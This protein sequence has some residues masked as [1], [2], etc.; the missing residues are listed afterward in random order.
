MNSREKKIVDTV[1]E[2][3][4]EKGPK[5]KMEDV[6]FAMKMS[7]KTIYKDFGNK[8]DLIILIVK[9]IFEGIEKQ[10]EKIIK[11]DKYDTLEK[12]IRI[13]CAYPDV[14]D[15][16]YHKAIMLKNDFPKPYKMFIS[17]IEDNWKFNKQLF[18]Q[19]IEEGV[20]K[21]IDHEVYRII[22]LGVTKQVLWMDDV[23]QEEL[24]VKC[25]RQV[26]E[27]FIVR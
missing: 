17:Y 10:L 2:L 6:A 16:D 4:T 12:L 23:N 27:G 3:F 8:E 26:I 9:A 24:L 1:L 7:K 5:F 25:V 19:C 11:S 14:A 20:L 21:P 22:V 18:N 15:V 13:T